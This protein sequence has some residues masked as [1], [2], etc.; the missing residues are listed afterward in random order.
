MF[1]DIRLPFWF[2][3]FGKEVSE[4]Q[5]RQHPLFAVVNESFHRPVFR[6]DCACPASEAT[7]SAG[8]CRLVNNEWTFALRVGI[9]VKCD[10]LLIIPTPRWWVIEEIHPDIVQPE[11]DN[12]RIDVGVWQC[13]VP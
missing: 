4:F 1:A 6:D 7:V 5:Q 2:L 13:G 3:R 11:I 9:S 12:R 10:E 8:R